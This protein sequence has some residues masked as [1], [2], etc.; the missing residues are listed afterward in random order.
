MIVFE[1]LLES[2]VSAD[3]SLK[4]EIH[5]LRAQMSSVTVHT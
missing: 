5:L 3:G 2:G 4:I 1:M